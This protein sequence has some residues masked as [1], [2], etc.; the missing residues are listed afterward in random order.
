V[1]PGRNSDTPLANVLTGPLTALGGGALSMAGFLTQ[2]AQ[3]ASVN[4]LAEHGI[5]SDEQE[6]RISNRAEI[7]FRGVNGS[8][9]YHPI[10]IRSIRTLTHFSLGG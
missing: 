8:K 5:L 3:P 6:E 10:H 7:H 2:F 1:S 9:P 4:L